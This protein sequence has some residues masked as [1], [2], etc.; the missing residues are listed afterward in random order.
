LDYDEFIQQ[1]LGER[2]IELEQWQQRVFGR[3][4]LVRGRRGIGKLVNDL[5]R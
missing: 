2:R 5:N 4:W 1:P 3:W